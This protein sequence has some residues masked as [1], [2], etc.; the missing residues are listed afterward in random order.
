MAGMVWPVEVWYG[1]V[2]WGLVWQAWIENYIIQ[3]EA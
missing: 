3:E 2:W 1:R